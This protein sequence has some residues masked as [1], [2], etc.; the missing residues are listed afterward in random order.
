MANAAFN[1]RWEFPKS[2]DETAKSFKTIKS[3][4][5]NAAKDAQSANK[6]IGDANKSIE[7]TRNKIA[8]LDAELSKLQSDRNKLTFQLKVAVDYGDTLRADDIRAE[9]QKNAVAQQKNRTDRKNAEGDQAGNYQKLYEAMQK[10]SDAQQKARRDLAGFSDAAREQRGNVLS[11]V[12]AYQKQV[13]AYANTG[14]SQQQVLAYAS[15]LRAEFINNM[16]SMGYSRAETER[17]AATFTDLSKVINGVPRNF[18]VGVN[19]DPALRALSDLEAKNRKSQHS[20]DDN[21]DAADKLGNSLNNTGGD[22]AGLGGALGGGGVGGAAEQAA[23]TFQQ[24][25]QITGNIGAEMWKAAGSANTAAHGLGN[26]GNQAHGSAYSMDV[27]GNKAGW[28]SYAINGIREAGY[29]AFSNI[30]SSAQQAGFSFNQAATDAI[31]LCNRVRD[32][33]SLSV[34]QFMFGFNQ[35][36]GFSTGGKVG[37]SS[38]SGGKQST[39]T[40][41][42]MLTPGEFVINRQAA[43][44]VGYGFLEAVNSGRAAASGASAASSGGAGGGFGGGPIL[45]ELSGTD[46]HILVSAVNKPTVIDGNAIVGMVN[47]SNAM[48]SRRGA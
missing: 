37:G 9:L 5:E 17:Y 31:N 46:R 4:F 33:R 1:F 23:V 22:A 12:E 38:Y 14:A 11:L 7:E 21:R 41:P 28:M 19:A 43:Q 29:G 13:L 34:G 44:T 20:M 26:M 16:T 15:A 47:G 42:A 45:V 25:G 48:A 39:D 6:E 32:L 27:A 3:Y 36:W 8:E 35:A 2:L 30:I 10:L 40:V 18:T 24:L